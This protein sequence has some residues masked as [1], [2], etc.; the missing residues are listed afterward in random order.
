MSTTG[1]EAVTESPRGNY[2]LSQFDT[3]ICGMRHLKW[4]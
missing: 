2:T 3:I 1:P 4:A